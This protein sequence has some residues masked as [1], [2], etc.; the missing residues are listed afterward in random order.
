MNIYLKTALLIFVT[1]LISPCLLGNE[2]ELSNDTIKK[3]VLRTPDERFTDLHEFPFE[4][5]YIFID[6]LRIHYIDEESKGCGSNHSIS[7]R[8]HLE[9]FV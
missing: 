8:A 2:S 1:V 4:P 6:G 7:W 3:G 9:L 5:N